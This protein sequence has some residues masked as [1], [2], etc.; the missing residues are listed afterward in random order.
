MNSSLYDYTDKSVRNAG[1]AAIVYGVA[2]LVSALL[3]WL[4]FFLY[5]RVSSGDSLDHSWLSQQ[6]L[7]HTPGRSATALVVG[8]LAAAISG[9]LA[10]GIFRRSKI[11]IV[12]MLLVVIVLQLHTWFILHSISGS[13][14]SIIVAAFLVRG[15]ARI[16]E[17][18]I[19]DDV[20]HRPQV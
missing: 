17:R 15:A 16:F 1:T 11:A 8:V 19:E 14:V 18:P 3:E 7:E 6:W 9:I 20:S 10:A 13:F 4:Q 12:L 5:H 2:A